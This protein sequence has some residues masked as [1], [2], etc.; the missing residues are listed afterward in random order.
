MIMFRLSVISL[1][2]PFTAMMLG[3]F[4]YCNVRAS[5]SSFIRS[6]SVI[7]FMLICLMVFGFAVNLTYTRCVFKVLFPFSSSSIYLTFLNLSLR[8]KVLSGN[9]RPDKVADF[10]LFTRGV[11]IFCFCFAIFI[12]MKYFW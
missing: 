9:F 10:L 5:S 1:K 8:C 3:W 4:I 2:H 6:S 11:D 12:F 7:S